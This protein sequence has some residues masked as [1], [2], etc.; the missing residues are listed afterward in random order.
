MRLKEFLLEKDE[1]IK[2]KATGVVGF[3][4]GRTKSKAGKTYH[5]IHV[6]WTEKDNK[7]FEKYW[8]KKRPKDSTG[9]YEWQREVM[10]ERI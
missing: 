9:R 1:Q 7:D 10:F 5:Q 4:T 3:L 2:M 6:P 8:G